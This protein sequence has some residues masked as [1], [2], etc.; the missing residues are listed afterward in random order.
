MSKGAI[1]PQGRGH[2]VPKGLIWQDLCRGS[3]L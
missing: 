3:V 1:D 2:F